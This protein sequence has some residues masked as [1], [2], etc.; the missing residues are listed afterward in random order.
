MTKK[1]EAEFAALAE[2]VRLIRALRWSRY[3]PV[4][5]DLLKPQGYV[6]Y[7]EGFGHNV[8][9][10]SQYGSAAPVYPMWSE[11]VSHGT[12]SHAKRSGGTQ[13]GKALYSTRLLAL[14]ALRYE[15]ELQAANS[16]ARIDRMIEEEEAQA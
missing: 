6:E 2:Q 15:A 16:L 13:G 8:H 1:Q 3:E 14:R 12:G 9:C 7:T 11:C 4:E 5:P 10:L